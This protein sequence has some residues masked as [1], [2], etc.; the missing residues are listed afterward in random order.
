MIYFFVFFIGS[1]IGSFL[2]VVIYRSI[3]EI[4]II[5]PPSFCP[6][7]KAPIKWYDNIPIISYILLSGKCRSCGGD[8]SISYILV[9]L[10]S[11]FLTLIFFVKWWDINKI[12]FLGSCLISYVLVIVSVI[13]IKTMMLS[14][15]F[16]YLLGLF[17]ISFAFFNPMFEGSIYERLLSAIYGI[18][19]GAGFMYLLLVVG[20][21]VYKKDAVGEGDVFLLG[22][23]GSI[24][25]SW[26][27]FDVI[28]LS[29]LVGTVYSIFGILNK[30]LHKHSAVPFGPFLATACI[31]KIYH[32]FSLIQIL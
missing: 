13:D 10:I 15:I 17:G 20:K 24:V 8:I 5:F 31:I 25:G 11:G 9:E 21:T 18:L 7:C 26:G 1:C 28:F 30:K 32:P 4:S 16:S 12:W 6:Q 2:N 29:S 27:I 14:D 3:K 22:G 19:I 23:I